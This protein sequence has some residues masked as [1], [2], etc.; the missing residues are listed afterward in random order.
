MV[1]WKYPLSEGITVPDVDG[2]DTM[3]NIAIKRSH[4]DTALRKTKK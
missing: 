2:L 1:S 3:D 4:D